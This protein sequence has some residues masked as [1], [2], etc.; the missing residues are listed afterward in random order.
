MA[1]YALTPE[2]M[3]IIEQGVRDGLP[4][5]TVATIAGV[6]Y[7]T[8]NDWLRIAQGKADAWS[9]GTPITEESRAQL[10]QL[11]EVIARAAAER[12]AEA[13]R[14][15][16]QAARIPDKYGRYDWRAEEFWLKNSA[17]TR[18]NWYEHRPVQ[19]EGN[20]TVNVVHRLVRDLPTP[21]LKEALPAEFRELMDE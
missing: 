11:S 18:K 3:N 5:E 16:R 19:V 21:Q 14:H 13:V 12:E 9:N 6:G 2:V 7:S 10:S 4:L 1:L 8:L 20:S 17:F 15:I